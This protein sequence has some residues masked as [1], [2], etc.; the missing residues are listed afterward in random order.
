MGEVEVGIKGGLG[1]RCLTW[2]GG[3][4]EGITCWGI[5]SVTSGVG[6]REMGFLVQSC[7][8]LNLHS[9]CST[10]PPPPFILSSSMDIYQATH[11]HT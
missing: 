11:I 6:R 3:R 9:G 5:L 4:G 7:Q 1:L 8:V 2:G 10:F